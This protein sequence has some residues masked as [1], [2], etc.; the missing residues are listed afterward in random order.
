MTALKPWFENIRS[1]IATTILG[2]IASLAVWYTIVEVRLARV[3]DR[4]ST[5][6]ME[7]ERIRAVREVDVERADKRLSEI[8]GK[9]TQILVILSTGRER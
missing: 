1:A 3:E 8:D 6:S 7:I 2:V 4:V 9:V 5:N